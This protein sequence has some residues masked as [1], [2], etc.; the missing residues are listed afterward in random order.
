MRRE[1]S[2]AGRDAPTAICLREAPAAHDR[3]VCPCALIRR[4]QTAGV[5]FDEIT[6]EIRA[7]RDVRD[8]KQFHGPREMAVGI[9]VEAAELL[10][11]FNWK[12]PAQCAE[13]IVER[14]TEI[15]EE[16][17]DVAILLFEM[18]DNSGIDLAAAMQRKLARN[19]LKYPVEKSPGSNRKYNEL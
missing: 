6:A 19:A 14:R 1:D 4:A 18:A 9:T 8:W 16:M 3:R 2:V 13:I 12:T 5:T 7:F 11:H 10:E 17:A 15:A